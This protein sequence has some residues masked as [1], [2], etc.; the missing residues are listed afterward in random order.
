[1]ALRTSRFAASNRYAEL[2]AGE[3]M[4]QTNEIVHELIETVDARSPAVLPSAEPTPSAL[5]SDHPAGDVPAGEAPSREAAED[6]RVETDSTERDTESA[7]VAIRRGPGDRA[8]R[9]TEM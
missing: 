5:A 7:E 6:D 3:D 2:V 4:I 9:R 8:D 1:M